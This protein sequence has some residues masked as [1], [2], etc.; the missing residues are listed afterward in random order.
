[1][2]SR[3]PFPI[4]RRNAFLM[5][6]IALLILSVFQRPSL[7]AHVGSLGG[8]VKL[9]LV[10]F[11]SIYASLAFYQ[12]ANVILGNNGLP[13]YTRPGGLQVFMGL[14]IGTCFLFFLA[15]CLLGSIGLP[16]LIRQKALVYLFFAELCLLI[17]LSEWVWIRR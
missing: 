13:W 16:C 14:V 8:W 4:R 11:S 5:L 9:I 10:S 17:P 2:L 1:M 15:D 3:T 6:T 7:L 12:I